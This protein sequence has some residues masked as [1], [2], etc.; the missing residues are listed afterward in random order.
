M[1]EYDKKDI[2]DAKT[3]G[4]AR[5]DRP[6]AKGTYEAEIVDGVE[7]NGPKGVCGKL[8][9]EALADDNAAPEGPVKLDHY[10]ATLGSVKE[11][12]LIVAPELLQKN[13]VRYEPA[14][15]V[16]SRCLIVVGEEDYNGQMRPRITRLLPL[17]AR[18]GASAPA[19]QAA[20]PATN[21][22]TKPA[23]RRQTAAKSDDELPF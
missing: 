14:D 1:I 21:P 2:D 13:P 8:T 5:W 20:K 15:Y 19:A 12:L 6:L 23:P 22:A 7:H 9:F 3:G 17:E 4:L 10:L 16:G 11:F 18:K